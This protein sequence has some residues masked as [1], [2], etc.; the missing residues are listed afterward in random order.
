VLTPSLVGAET[1]GS[2]GAYT[3]LK[4]LE[5]S[6]PTELRKNWYNVWRETR[7]ATQQNRAV[8][9][10][11]SLP[12][13]SVLTQSLVGTETLGS[14]GAYI[15]PEDLEVSAPTELR[16]QFYNMGGETLHCRSPL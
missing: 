14:Y 5:V 6:A 8:E 7:I 11:V 16:N 12:E 13:L 3:P 1:L 15:Q 9:T 10:L 4:D 2:S